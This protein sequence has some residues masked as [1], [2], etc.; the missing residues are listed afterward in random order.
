M[1]QFQSEERCAICGKGIV[2][3]V[4]T[5]DQAVAISRCRAGRLRSFF[6]HQ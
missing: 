1:A 6:G 3:R 2:S 4:A 5:I